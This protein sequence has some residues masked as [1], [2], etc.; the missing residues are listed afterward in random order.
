MVMMKFIPYIASGFQMGCYH[1]I[2]M[3]LKPTKK[4]H[5]HFPQTDLYIKVMYF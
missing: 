4:G 3:W 2:E 5:N 1:N